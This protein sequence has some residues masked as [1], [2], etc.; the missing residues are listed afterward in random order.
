M[1]VLLM[2]VF[3]LLPCSVFAEDLQ[4]FSQRLLSQ[5]TT[6]PTGILVIPN[7]QGGVSYWRGQGG[8]DA[9]TAGLIGQGLTQQF[10]QMQPRTPRYAPPP[11]TLPPSFSQRISCI[12]L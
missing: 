11:L 5:N 10:Q 6:A 1:R 2:L 12:F 9:Y 8:T 4:T 3:I 7:G